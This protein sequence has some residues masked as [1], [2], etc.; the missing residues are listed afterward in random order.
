[1]FTN[2]ITC[3]HILNIKLFLE[4]Y[5]ASTGYMT[6][7]L[8]NQGVSTNSTICD[9]ITVELRNVIFPYNIIEKV[10]TL[11][12]TDGTAT[13][14]FTTSGTYYIVINHRNSLQTWSALPVELFNNT[15]YDF[16]SM[17][18]KAYGNNMLQIDSNIW[19]IYSGD[20][21]Q[22]ENIDL[23]DLSLLENDISSFQ[24]G[25]STS[26]IN[27][28]GNVDLLDSPTPEENSNNFIFSNHP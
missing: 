1:M 3:D 25:Y 20:V 26:D 18:S 11:L 10:T 16:S 23:L 27:G 12:N 24:F 22:D 14:T 17:G 2:G 4:G 9:S 6:S 5:Y 21:N 19:A 8:M 7:V 13:C 28:D 15:S